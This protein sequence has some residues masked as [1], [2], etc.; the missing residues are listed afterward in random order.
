MITRKLLL[1]KIKEDFFVKTYL[2]SHLEKENFNLIMTMDCEGTN[3]DKNLR[4]NVSHLEKF[5]YRNTNADIA[6]VLFLTPYFVDMMHQL[7]IVESVKNNYNVIFGLHIH[8]NNLPPELERQCSFAAKEEN[9]IG[10]YNCDE[11]L[12]M[13]KHSAKYLADRGITDLQAF[14][15]GYFSMNNDTAKALQAVTQ[16]GYE[17][18]NIYRAEYQV[19]N[20]L[21]TPF[22]VYAFDEEEEFRLEYFDSSKLVKMLYGAAEKR[23]SITGITHSYLLREKEIHNKM[24]DIIHE[25]KASNLFDIIK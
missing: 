10:A 20:A 12:I 24:E 13:I 18:H 25:I 1:S 19:T 9:L 22:P 6:T 16:I 11:Q 21:L 7:K 4:E 17:S 2:K 5:L 23:T 3:F 14:R 15:G 8:P